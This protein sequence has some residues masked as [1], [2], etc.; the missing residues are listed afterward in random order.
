MN[1]GE[2]VD[3]MIDHLLAERWHSDRID[4]IE[5]TAEFRA[6][7]LRAVVMSRP[8]SGAAFVEAFIAAVDHEASRCRTLH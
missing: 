5:V 7:V 1:P 3:D 4:G 6:N 8:R 2:L